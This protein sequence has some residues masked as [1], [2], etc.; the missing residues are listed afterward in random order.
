LNWQRIDPQGDYACEPEESDHNGDPIEVLLFF[1]D[2]G[3]AVCGGIPPRKVKKSAS[4]A[5]MK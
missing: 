4:L 1:Y 2:G 5:L 3:S